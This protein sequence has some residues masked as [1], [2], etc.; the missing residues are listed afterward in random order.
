MK[1]EITAPFNF[2]PLN[3]DVYFPDWSGKVLHDVPLKDAESGEIE[4]VIK[5]ISPVFIRDSEDEGRFF[6]FNGEYLIPGSSFKGMLRSVLEIMSFA[7]LSED[8]IDDNRYAVRDLSKADNFYMKEMKEGVRAGWLVKK[9]GKYIIE[10]CGEP[11]RISHKEIDK[12]LNITFSKHFESDGF[13]KTSKYKYDII[14]GPY[15]KIKVGNPYYSS[16]N[17]KYDKRKFT[18]YDPNGKE[19]IL[20]LT[21]Q[22]TK[23]KNSGKKGDGKGFEFVF[24]PP[25][26]ELDVDTDVFEDFKFAY[27]DGRET[28]PK[29]SPDWAYW[30]VKLENNQKVPVFFKEKDKKVLHFGLSYL[31]KLPY[32]HTVSRGIVKIHF[33]TRKDLPETIFGYTGK[34]DSLKGR[35]FV[36]H[37]K[38]VENIKELP[39]RSVVLGTPRASY[40]P[41]Y[42]KQNG[43]RYITYMDEGFEIAGRKRYPVRKNSSIV[44][45]KNSGNDQMVFKF[46]PLAEGVV[47]KGKIRFFNLNRVE[48]GALLSAL[49]FHNTPGTYHSIG[50]GKPLGYGKIKVDVKYGNMLEYMKEFEKEITL[51][52]KNW[53]EREELSELVTM[54]SE[55]NADEDLKYMDVKTYSSLKN[56][57]QYLK[58]YSQLKKVQ[59]IKIKSLLTQEELESFESE[60]NYKKEFEKVMNSNDINVLEKFLEKV[61]N[62]DK[63][64]VVEKIQNL[65]AE[66]EKKKEDKFKQINQKALQAFNEV[67]SKKGSKGFEKAKDKF[68]KKWSKEKENKGSVFVLNLLEEVK[69]L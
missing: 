58:R 45:T 50:M 14:G 38:A 2:I 56:T 5:A 46:R 62:E 48:I 4:I 8:L 59:K 63:Q 33:D 40:Y 13:E 47:F 32:K 24:M 30:K 35:V 36:S 27:F 3:K 55:Q 68:I 44:N 7:K 53:A 16:S 31:Y 17:R 20:V 34:N 21:G 26:R 41:I 18:K 25:L 39:E 1:R 11:L 42:I 23:R 69:K 15:K 60:K 43:G 28:Q 67:K 10:D 61:K 51:H 9:D 49:T 52:I 6:N 54:A 22:P 65:K 12:A 19:G 29:E 37:F 57:A 66:I 64:A